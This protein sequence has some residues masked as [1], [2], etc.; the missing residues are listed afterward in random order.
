VPPRG[1]TE[2]FGFVSGIGFELDCSDI[3]NS[4]TS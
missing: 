1:R 3:R 2:Y 4:R